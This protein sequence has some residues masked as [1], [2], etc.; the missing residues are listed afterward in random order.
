MSDGGG[1]RVVSA[2]HD[3]LVA[4]CEGPAYRLYVLA[5]LFLVYAFNFIDRMLIGI[6]AP[7][8]KRDLGVTDAQ[9]GLMSGTAFAL[10]YTTLAIPIA[11][12]ADRHSRTWIIA[13]ALAVWSG[14]TALSGAAAGFGGLFLARLGVGVGEAGGA[15]PSYSLIAD[16]FPPGQRA[17]A[18][19]A[20][21]FGVP[22]GTAAGLV[23]GGVLA[24]LVDW[25]M[26]F[27]TIGI[28]G[29]VLAPVFKA[30][31]REPQR[32]RFD[33]SRTAGQARVREVAAYL[34]GKP[35]FWFLAL[36]GAFASLFSFGLFFWA[37]SVMVRS[38]GMTLREASLAYGAA[39]IVGGLPGVWLGGVI[40]DRF[41]HA[42][43]KFYGL[44]PAAGYAVAIPALLV[45]LSAPVR[46]VS[47]A[48]LAIVTLIGFLANAPTMTAVQ[49]LAPPNMRATT[50]A[51]FLF[52]NAAIAMGMGTPLLGWLS[53]HLTTV[54][55]ADGLRYALAGSTLAYVLAAV[56]LILASSRLDPEW[57][58]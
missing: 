19:S 11:A 42:G 22:V 12:L 32:A 36:G 53:D 29:V 46:E 14:F 15:A 8:I 25:R 54:H 3:D 10:F 43:R 33:R 4:P 23:L 26:A 34:R 47:F 35:G 13:V 49:H 20:Y 55:G 41:A 51:I 56:F 24:S 50:T 2:R 38:F 5:M 28:A 30:T 27:F 57:V 44:I 48:L 31:V 16:Y 58:D 18:Y 1:L 45:C 52:V 6:L 40:G 39:M 21:A 7:L 17:R 9:L 37:P